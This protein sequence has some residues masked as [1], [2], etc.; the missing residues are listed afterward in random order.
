MAR[1]SS[2]PSGEVPSGSASAPALLTSTST[3]PTCL[4]ERPHR[5]QVRDVQQ[6]E[7]DVALHLVGGRLAAVE[8]AH[9]EHDLGAALGEHL[10][11]L[12]ADAAAGAGHHEPA[13]VLARAPPASASVAVTPGRARR[14]CALDV[15]DG[16]A[17]GHRPADG[18]EPVLDLLDG[19][20]QDLA[21]RV[22][23]LAL[24]E[25]DVEGHLELRPCALPPSSRT[26]WPS[27]RASEGLERRPLA[28]D[29][30][31]V[32]GTAA[33]QG[34]EQQLDGR[35]V[36]IL[37][38]A[39]GHAAAAARW[40]PSSGAHRSGGGRRCDGSGHSAGSRARLPWRQPARAPDIARPRH[41]SCLET[42]SS[43]ERCRSA[44]CVGGAGPFPRNTTDPEPH[45]LG[46]RC[47]TVTRGELRPTAVPLGGCG[48]GGGLSE[49][50]LGSAEDQCLRCSRARRRR[51]SSRVSPLV[52]SEAR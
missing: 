24:G 20:R 7:L 29:V 1:C 6:P 12:E 46:V 11:G 25:G 40:S 10:G 14:A 38:G 8:V 19:A 52:R 43:P 47:W 26:L 48:L 23:A 39:D 51:R 28:R 13:A 37:A 22:A 32:G 50:P 21:G 9:R 35:E 34:R 31:E 27:A 3:G 5:R 15:G 36:G 42:T 49:R 33:D 4:G 30:V 16:V 41:R 44:T 2:T 45:G 18:A 17:E